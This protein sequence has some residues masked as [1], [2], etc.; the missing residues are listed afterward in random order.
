MKFTYTTTIL[1]SS[2]ILLLTTLSGAFASDSE[3]TDLFHTEKGIGLGV[4]SVVGGVIAGPIGILTGAMVGSLI[5]HNIVVENEKQHLIQSK[6]ELNSKLVESSEKLQ[7]LEDTW[8]RQNIILND[9]H[10]T[11]E[12][13]LA[14]NQELKNHALNFDVQFRTNST[15]I[16]KQYQEYLVAL[17]NAL[18]ETP[19]IELEVAGF[20]DRMGDEDYNMN[21]S[22]KRAQRVKNFLIQQGI[23]EDRITTLAY[24][25]SQPLHPE[26]NLENNFFDRRVS[27]YI[28]PFEISSKNIAD[29]IVATENELAIA[30][31]KR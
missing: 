16:E 28:R 17:A 13:L 9:A 11:I 14:Q 8:S 10:L 3:N 20:A 26:E 12:K 1:T 22:D 5:G 2:L 31:N 30:T 24:G 23:E 21:L 25:E 7:S 29:E 6:D 4:G 27:I 19:N 15:N 18:N